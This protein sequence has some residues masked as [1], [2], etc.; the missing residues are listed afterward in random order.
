VLV[1]LSKNK[2]GGFSFNP[3]AVNFLTELAKTVFAFLTLISLVSVRQ[4]VTPDNA[5][6]ISRCPVVV[7]QLCAYCTHM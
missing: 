3:V 7:Q 1:H 6:A 5:E 4:G 2:S